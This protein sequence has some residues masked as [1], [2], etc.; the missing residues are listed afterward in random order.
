MSNFQTAANES[1]NVIR[2]SM[3]RGEAAVERSAEVGQEA[4]SMAAENSSEL[5]LKIIE[6]ARANT[7]EFFD[8]TEKLATTK[9]PTAL[10]ELWKDHTQK[11]FQMFSKQSQE[12]MMLGQQL[13][14]KSVTLVPR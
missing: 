10:M 6:I 5:S 8:F 2:D 1:A 7:E 12:L 3:K 13:A 4:F 14:G 11:Q 9:D